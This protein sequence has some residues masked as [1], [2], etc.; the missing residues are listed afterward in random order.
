MTYIKIG[1]FFPSIGCQTTWL[2][3]KK[4]KED[5]EI[6]CYVFY[7]VTESVTKVT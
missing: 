2:T 1:P 4:K 6:L 5:E 3:E 7:L